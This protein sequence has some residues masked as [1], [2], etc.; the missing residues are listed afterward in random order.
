MTIHS[1]SC[2]SQPLLCEDQEEELS[3]CMRSR[4]GLCISERTKSS[5]LIGTHG[6]FG[7]AC[8]ALSTA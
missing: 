7:D 8:N 1:R 6:V 2:G 5:Y 4:E 3:R